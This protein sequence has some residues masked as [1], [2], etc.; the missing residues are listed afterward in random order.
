MHIAVPK[1]AGHDGQS[2]DPQSLERGCTLRARGHAGCGGDV[3][4]GCFHLSDRGGAA[5]MW[6]RRLDARYEKNA[7]GRRCAMLRCSLRSGSDLTSAAACSESAL[8]NQRLRS[9]GAGSSMTWSRAAFEASNS[10]RRMIM[11]EQPK[12]SIALAGASRDRFAC[13]SP[14]FP[15]GFGVFDCPM[16]VGPKPPR[17]QGE[18]LRQSVLAATL[19][20]CTS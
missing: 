19:Q 10:S 2:F 11:H 5:R 9:T 17:R 8:P 1:T 3:R 14:K 15:H 6:H 12:V 16:I 4:D 7:L 18:L 13:V 20:Y